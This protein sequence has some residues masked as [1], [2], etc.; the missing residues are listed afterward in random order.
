MRDDHL[1]SVRRVATECGQACEST[2]LMCLACPFTSRASRAS[3]PTPSADPKPRVAL[4]LLALGLC[5][6]PQW[7]EGLA[8]EAIR[9]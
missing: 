5:A 2:R 7:R 9:P 8:P 3:G 4:D 1:E 6:P